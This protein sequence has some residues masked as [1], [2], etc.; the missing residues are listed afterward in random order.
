MKKSLIVIFCAVLGVIA[1][2]TAAFLIAKPT[3]KTNDIAVQGSNIVS[4]IESTSQAV[5]STKEELFLKISEPHSKKVTTKADSITFKGNTNVPTGVELNGKQIK[6][7]KDKDG[8]FTSKQSLKYGD[9]KFTFKAGEFTKTY[10]IYRK[11]TVI[12]NHSPKTEQTHSAGAKFTVSVTAR[13][14]AKVTAKFN[15]KTITL[16]ANSTDKDF[17][18]FTGSFTLPSG[19]FKDL[20]LGKI[21]FKAKYKDYTD[22]VYSKNI[23][24]KKEKLVVSYDEDATPSGSDY[25]NVGSGIITEIVAFQA[26]TFKGTGKTDASKPYYNY[27][28]KGTVDYGSSEYET[29]KRDGEKLK[30]ITLRCGRKVYKARYDKPP[31]T[32]VTI[33]KQYV[34]TLPDHNEISVATLTDNSTHTILTLDTL[35]KAPFNFELKKQKYKSDCTV[36]DIT[37]NYV[38]I[39]FCYAT[40]FEGEVSIPKSNPLFSK[41]KIIKNKS[42]YTLR[43][44]LKKQGGFYGWDA[45]YNSSNQLC[46]EFL[47]PAKITLC[48]NEYGADL[49]GVKILIDVGHGGIDSGAVKFGGYKHREAARN[50]VLAKK[51]A[52]E[53]KA[54]GATV[55]MTRTDDSTR[56]ADYKCKQL[57]SLKP[58]YCIA[59]HHDFNNTSSLNGFGAYYYYPFSKNAAEYVADHTYNTGIYKNKR[60]KWHYYFMSRVSVCPVVLTENGYISNRYDYNS[61]KS[62]DAN[63]KKAKAMAKG[64]VEYFVSIQ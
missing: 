18:E 51:L 37:Y 45:Y 33:A 2:L 6:L 62:S 21:K 32:K 46:F 42:D 13:A 35:W 56:T 31:K 1:A 63:T 50:L 19:H 28:P 59:I 14:K 48:D 22:T 23:I 34:G 53:L 20:D 30:L 41:A 40:K 52:A 61:I 16:K 25:I 15:G 24:C 29:V 5:Q 49:S 10:N 3:D 54:I 58:D 11:Y 43:L 64:I 39:T 38:D 9:N 44:Y 8:S 4:E 12:K 60:F 17:A 55:Y 36:S 26:E 7:R 57:K 47:N 27:L